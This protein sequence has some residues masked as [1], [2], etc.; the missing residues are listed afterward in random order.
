MKRTGPD[1]LAGGLAVLCAAVASGAPWVPVR[2]VA[3]VPLGLL[4]PGFALTRAI[5]A[6]SQPDALP[7]QVMRVTLTVALSIATL[8]IGALVLNGMPGGIQRTSWAVLLAVVTV[9]ASAASMALRWR[10][11]PPATMPRLPRVR[12][13]STLTVLLASAIAIGALIASRIPLRAPNAVGYTQLSILPTKAGRSVNVSVTC[14]QL[15]TTSYRLV[16]HG[17]GKTR[18]LRLTLAPGASRSVLVRV[19]SARTGY[20]SATLRR[21]GQAR[22]YRQVRLAL[23]SL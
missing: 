22:P 13:G 11:G 12:I 23:R 14:D 20:V 17:A 15:H 6:R 21:T 7:T 4:L 19:H 1:V 10:D 16:I 9:S 8:I 2:T 3:T 18:S 5:F